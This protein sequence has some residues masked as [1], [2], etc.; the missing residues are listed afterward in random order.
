MLCF[1]VICRGTPHITEDGRQVHLFPTQ[2]T[3]NTPWLFARFDPEFNE[4]F[5]FD[6]KY[7]ADTIDAEYHYVAENDRCT[8]IR[9]NYKAKNF[10]FVCVDL[11]NPS[12]V[13]LQ[14]VS[15]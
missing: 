2:G 11:S 14:P 1:G 9:T 4:S 10:R 5:K 6:F 15:C 3:S 13:S 12:R 8:Y 7:I